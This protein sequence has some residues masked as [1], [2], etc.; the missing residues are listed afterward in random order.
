MALV[1]TRS[2]DGEGVSP[3]GLLARKDARRFAAGSTE[4][5]GG[6]GLCVAT[7]YSRARCSAPCTGRGREL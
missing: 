2:L 6:Q 5:R 7:G 3:S 4:T 1:K